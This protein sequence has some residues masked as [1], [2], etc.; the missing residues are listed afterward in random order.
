MKK[1]LGLDLGVASIGWSLIEKNENGGKILKSGGRIFQA[2]NERAIAA[3]GESAKSDR[4]TKRSVRRQIDRRARRKQ[5]L[6]N[7][8]FKKGLTPQKEELKNWINLNPYE[9]RAKSLDEKIELIELGRAL[10]HLNQHRGYKSNRK[11]GEDKDGAVSQGI[12]KITHLIDKYNARTFG[13]YCYLI[14]E[15][16]KKINKSPSDDDWRI[17]NNYTHRDMYLFEFDE[18][19]KAQ[20]KFYPKILNNELKKEIFK[21]IFF[22]RKMKSQA[23]LIG[24]CILEKNK[25]RIPKAHLLFQ[26]FRLRKEINNLTLSD[27]NGLPIEL[28]LEDKEHLFNFL[29]T[30]ADASFSALKKVLVKNEVISNTNVFF[31]LERGERKKLKGNTTNYRLASK[32]A[33]GEDWYSIDRHLQN[34]IVYVLIH[35]DDP[36]KVINKAVNEWN[37]SHDQAKTLSY[38][39][40]ESDYG[41]L[42]EK[43]IKKLLPHLKN[44]LEESVAIIEAGYDLFEN[45]QGVL[46][47]LP[48]PPEIKNSVVYHAL[49]E[50][51]KV[52]NGIIRVYGMPDKIRV[53]LTRD[54]KAGY[55]RR[56]KMTKKMRDLEKRNEKAKAALMKSPFNRQEPTYND[57]LWYNL[58]EECERI[59]PYTSKSIPAEAFNT[60]EFQVEHIIPFSRCLDNSYANKTLC[61]ADFNRKKG[62]RTPWECV[63]A[64][65]VFEDDLL[66][67][68]RKLPWNKQKKFVQKT[69]DESKFINRQLSDTRYISKEASMYLKQ[70]ACEDVE[71]VKG[72]TTSLLRHIWGLNGVLNP[73][74][75][76]MKNREDHR[77]H[78]LD[79]IVVALTT[80]SIL[81]RLSDENKKLSEDEWR[82]LEETGREQYEEMKKRI[83]GRI[84]LSYPWP[85]FR[86]DVERSINNI[87]VSHRVKRKISGALHEETFYGFTNEK[88]PKKKAMMVKRKPVH[89]LSAK[90]LKHIRDV[91][92]RNIVNTTVE[93]RM[94]AG[95]SQANAIKSMEADPPYIV[96]D[97]AK[98]PIRKVRLLEEKTP[99]IMHAFS[100]EHGIPFKHALYGSNHHI[101][102]YDTEDKNGK[103]I[104]VGF[105]VSTMEAA[106][107]VK[108]GEPIIDRNYRPHDYT[109]K[110]SLSIND[111]ITNQEDGQIYRVQ[112]LASDGTITFRKSEIAL[113]GQSDPGVLRKTPSTLNAEKI[114][115]SPIGEVFP[116][117]D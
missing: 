117:H 82:T 88:A 61:D 2:N 5:K 75:D 77:H 113:K 23:H 115:I 28:T 51:R 48:M 40:L 32:H 109:F 3:P 106:R 21:T 36:K 30:R 19:W 80:R 52:I 11:D 78:A 45:K 31:N 4:G 34:Y 25:K 46:N 14:H 103:K 104:Q 6:F 35:F 71:V 29:N 58:W 76:E 59:C 42:S 57:I 98:V 60:G 73:E 22:Q 64:G 74:N 96:S 27:E 83:N 91:G 116:A 43:A 66:Q 101:A 39:K 67:R 1:I 97:K 50:L 49:I 86:N 13:E 105:V 26:E 9:F 18:I 20:S 72:Q 84:W 70:L 110:Y 8:L 10:Y 37:R 102:I 68:K 62:N 90:E 81:K 112:K 33:F 89:T 16:H 79:A 94:Q 93:H 92:I 54:I 87:T 41:S 15:N 38:L 85:S 12:K 44:G 65:L 108:D 63:E 55:D 100:N 47:R 99:H 114:K 53:E 24:K 7:L 95:L 107:R 69:I 56:Q 17:R 111:M